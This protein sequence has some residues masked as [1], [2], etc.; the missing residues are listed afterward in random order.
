[1]SPKAFVGKRGGNSHMCVD[2][3]GGNSHHFRWD[4]SHLSEM[5]GFVS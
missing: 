4:D 2:G 1:M 3:P 5:F